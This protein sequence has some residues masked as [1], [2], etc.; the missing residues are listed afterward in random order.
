MVNPTTNGTTTSTVG[1]GSGAPTD[2]RTVRELRRWQLGTAPGPEL[3]ADALPA[4]LAPFRDPSRVRHDYP[5]VVGCPIDRPSEGLRARPLGELLPGWTRA[6]TAQPRVLHDNLL[7]LERVVRGLANAAPIHRA[8]S[9]LQVAGEQMLAE[10]QLRDGI[11]A[12]VRSDLA[13]IGKAV[14]TFEL[15]PLRPETPLCLLLAA[16]AQRTDTARA[17][18]LQRATTTGDGLRALLQVEA[19]KDPEARDASALQKNLGEVGS[20][21]LDPAALARMV[22]QHRGT[23]RTDPERRQRLQQALEA[24][25]RF[26]A[27]PAL[28]ALVVVHGGEAPTLPGARLV[29]AGEVCTAAAGCFDHYAEPLLA[30]LRAMQLAELEQRSAYEPERHDAMLAA[31]RWQD[32]SAAE[33]HVLPV[34]VALTSGSALAGHALPALVQLLGSGRPV[35]VLALQRPSDDPAHGEA[36]PSPARLE[37]GYLGIAFREAYVQQATAARPAHLLA[38]FQQALRGTRP[39][40][41]VV[42]SGLD[43]NGNEPP[44]GA[45]LHASAA[46]EGR[47]HPLFQY[48]PEAGDTWAKRVDFAGNPAPAA[49]WPANELSVPG[50]SDEQRPVVQFTFADYA[51]LEPALRGSFALLPDGLPTADLVPL[52]EYLQQ[53]ATAS[54]RALPF[55]WIA[56]GPGAGKLH[57]ALVQRPLI[58]ACRDRLRFWRTLQELAGVRN[59]YVREA[60]QRARQEAA[61]QATRERDALAARHR[62]ELEQVR[63]AATG[64]AMQGLARMLLELDPLGAP[65]ALPRA[66]TATVPPITRP[67]TPAPTAGTAAKPT[68]VAAPATATA[69]AAEADEP[70]IESVRCSTCND[71]VNLNS[72]LFAYDQNK[73]ARIADARAGTFAQ[74][75]LA[76]EKCPARCIHPGQPQNPNEPD[77][78]ALVVR[79][80][81]FNR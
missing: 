5:L 16:A 27:A 32:L 79:A 12:G 3:P 13:A 81:P 67:A 42:D 25:E 58:A 51:L 43:R 71:C 69:A 56:C 78:A 1:P 23:L 70:W 76:A 49:D 22:G 31:L 36:V 14:G 74:I 66:V 38:G 46:I 15:L 30:A 63:A 44:L 48:D 60:V 28:P 37:L 34:I 40:L 62:E 11:A 72:L 7:R 65:V 10:L 53:P 21:F 35:Q 26:L 2:A 19:Q 4:L 33:L 6:A 59:D 61:E 68:T 80:A 64:T 29:A 8:D 47:A 24:L 9:L 75:V 41:H 18:F 45:F 50:A 52:A 17:A 73:Q 20:R 57:R 55:V 39:G 77:L 54:S